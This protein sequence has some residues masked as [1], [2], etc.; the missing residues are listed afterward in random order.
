MIYLNYTYPITTVNSKNFQKTPHR[1]PLKKKRN[2]ISIKKL[3]IP[4]L[5]KTDPPW[6]FNIMKHLNAEMHYGNKNHCDP[7]TYR[8][9]F[10]EIKEKIRSKPSSIRIGH[11]TK[12]NS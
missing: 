3:Q 1:L 7:E 11:R 8:K 5:Q 12:K 10:E 2:H 6:S 4:T 9:F